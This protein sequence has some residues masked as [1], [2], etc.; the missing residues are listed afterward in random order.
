MSEVGV[1]L[2]L[3]CTICT[4]YLMH[5]NVLHLYTGAESDVPAWSYAW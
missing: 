2:K 3:D 4:L 5:S 1:I